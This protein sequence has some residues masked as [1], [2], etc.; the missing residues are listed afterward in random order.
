[1]LLYLKTLNQKQANKDSSRKY[2]RFTQ[3]EKETENSPRKVCITFKKRAEMG[4]YDNKVVQNIFA[5]IPLTYKF[6][7][8][9]QKGA[10]INMGVQRTPQVNTTPSFRGVRKPVHHTIPL[11]DM[12][13]T[14]A[15]GTFATLKEQLAAEFEQYKKIT[16]ECTGLFYKRGSKEDS[17]MKFEE[18]P[19]FFF[20]SVKKDEPVVAAPAPL[21]GTSNA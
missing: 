1:M 5:A 9:P 3:G 10:P 6:W 4:R 13:K 15:S 21:P 11:E 17:G 16:Q 19:K 2:A 14:T 18:A 7:S 8:K 12:T 20:G